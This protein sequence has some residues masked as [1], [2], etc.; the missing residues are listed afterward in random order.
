MLVGI[1]RKNSLGIEYLSKQSILYT[2]R[3]NVAK[4]NRG[5]GGKRSLDEQR[6]GVLLEEQQQHVEHGGWQQVARRLHVGAAQN[7]PREHVAHT[8][9]CNACKAQQRLVHKQMD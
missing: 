3:V 4:E 7:A 2:S 6:T 1:L 8:E 9:A 5:I